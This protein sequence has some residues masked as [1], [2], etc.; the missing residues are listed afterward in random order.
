M[1]TRCNFCGEILLCDRCKAVYYDDD[2]SQPCESRPLI[3]IGSGEDVDI[4]GIEIS[5]EK[6]VPISARSSNH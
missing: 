5:Q 4:S 6:R 1:T 3:F 2:D